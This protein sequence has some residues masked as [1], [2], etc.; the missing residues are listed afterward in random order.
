MTVKRLLGLASFVTCLAGASSVLAQAAPAA[1]PPAAPPAAPAPAPAPD[2]PP[3][4]APA[5]D[6]EAVKKAAEAA[7]LAAAT[8]KTKDVEADGVPEKA[9]PASDFWS[10]FSAGLL[11]NWFPKDIIEAAEIRNGVVRVTERKNVFA[12]VGLQ[13]F[14]PL[15]WWTWTYLRAPDLLPIT[16]ENKKWVKSSEV[17]VGP[18]VGASVS[19][20]TVIENV[21][22]GLAFSATTKSAGIR[23]GAGFVVD[24]S[25]QY[26]SP[27]FKDGQPPPMDSTGVS[28][29]KEVAYGGQL[30]LSFTPGFGSAEE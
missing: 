19:S 1:A 8:G 6:A 26:L 18:Y 3:P 11:V 30:M 22:V 27:E 2:Q 28:Y 13:A 9:R 5:P 23:I 14:Y 7:D 25:V 17:A 29:V 20:E 24:P 4:V 12:G 10:Y 15:P 21:A 16:N